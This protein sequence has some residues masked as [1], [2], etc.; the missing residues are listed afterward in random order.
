MKKIL[1]SLIALMGLSVWAANELSTSI[2]FQ[3][4]KGYDQINKNFS[5]Q[6]TV[7]GTSRAA[8]TIVAANTNATLLSLSGISTNGFALLRNSGTNGWFQF[9]SDGTNWLVNTQPGEPAIFRCATNSF[10]YQASTN[11]AAFTYDI[12]SN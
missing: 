3:Y 12:L 9:S 2:G 4:T 6:I 1:V 8:G 5:V 10:Y 7:N 11:G